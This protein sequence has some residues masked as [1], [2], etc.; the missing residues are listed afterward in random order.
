MA[1]S[2][3]SENKR[4]EN[5]PDENTREMRLN[6]IVAAYLQAQQSGGSPDRTALTQRY[7]EFADELA[8]FF[9]DQDRFHQAAGLFKVIDSEPTLVGADSPLLPT[10][11]RV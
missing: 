3:S 7:P 2:N 5:T 1:I 10:G 11:Q 9:I 6:E 8:S 4:D